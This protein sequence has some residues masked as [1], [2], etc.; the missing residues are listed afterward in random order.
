MANV[1]SLLQPSRRRTYSLFVSV[2]F[3]DETMVLKVHDIAQANIVDIFCGDQ[4]QYERWTRQWAKINDVFTDMKSIYDAPKK[5]F[6]KCNHNT[7]F[8]SSIP[9]NGDTAGKDRNQL[10]PFFVYSRILKNS[11]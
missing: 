1:F 6:Q 5:A 2:E 4:M 9:T 7:I 11:Y 10:D 3:F 8:V